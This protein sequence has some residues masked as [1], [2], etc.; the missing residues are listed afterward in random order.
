[1][2]TLRVALISDLHGNEIALDAVLAD[3]GRR[4]VEQTVCLGDVA[5]LGPR[6]VAVLERLQR[7][8]CV[9]ILGNHDEFMLEPSLV[10][11]YSKIP[12]LR[13]AVAWCRAR[14]PSDAVQYIRGF[15]R[16]F[17]LP[18]DQHNRLFL[19][20][21]TPESN[22]EDL[23]ATTPPE[24]LDEMLAGHRAAVMAGGHTHIQMLRQHRGIWVVNPGS[25]G[26][27][28]KEYVG[29]GPPIV[30]PY[31]EYA[32]IESVGGVLGVQLHRVPLDK[33]L[34]RQ[35]ALSVDNPLCA[36]LAQMYG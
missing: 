3:I 12:V 1:M 2:G 5:T 26:M 27:P 16:S 9:C 32:T 8:G 24:P 31:A 22:V 11:A 25:V 19:F 17:E 30:L 34:L 4:G 10:D 13:D 15:R 28:F 18:L 33:S 23:L 6:P 36:S 14:L 20:H 29:G 7:L 21:G 35:A